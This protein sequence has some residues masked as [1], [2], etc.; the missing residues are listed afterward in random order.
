MKTVRLKRSCQF[1]LHSFYLFWYFWI[2][3]TNPELILDSDH[4]Q[5]IRHNG[6]ASGFLAFLESLA[7]DQGSFSLLSRNLSQFHSGR[8]MACRETR[9]AHD[10]LMVL[11]AWNGNFPSVLP[12]LLL[13]FPNMMKI[14][15]NLNNIKD[16]K[17][18]E[19]ASLTSYFLWTVQNLNS[20]CNNVIVKNKTKLWNKHY[21]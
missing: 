9:T 1:T 14:D 5:M 21:V 4:A 19:S 16:I 7:Y 10:H 2:P 18:S 12:W 8:A 11:V 15:V 20:F 17:V 6:L 3:T 13:S